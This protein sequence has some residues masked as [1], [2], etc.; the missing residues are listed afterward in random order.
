MK[1]I[2]ILLIIYTFGVIVFFID[3]KVVEIE[4]ETIKQNIVSE[5]QEI[6]E[7]EENNKYLTGVWVSTVFNLDFPKTTNN[8]EQQLKAEIDEIIANSLANDISDIFFQVRPTAD[9]FYYSKIF[10]T[11]VY[12]TGNQ[13]ISAS[14]DVLEYFVTQAHKSNLKLHAWINP[15]RITKNSDDV[16]SDSHIAVTNPELTVT[17]TDGNLYFNPALEEVQELVVDGVLEILQNYDVDGIHLDD[18]FYPSQDFY[19]D[20]Q[21]ELYGDGRSLGDFRRDNVTNLIEKLYKT[22]K[23][24]DENIKF[25]VSPAGIWANQS[26]FYE[27]SATNGTESYFNQYADTKKWVEMGILDY[28]APQIYWQIGFDIADYEILSNWWSQV[29]E[30]TDVLLYIGHANYKETSGI[31]EV[32]EI[33]KQIDMNKQN[34]NING[35]IFF[36]YGDLVA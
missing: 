12:L 22:V 29:V 3:H 8:D 11:S 19:D 14:F 23:T 21:Y 15:Y 24:Y 28:I 36:R 1:K 7:I 32:G 9:A 27:G 34:D 25:G 17:H 4:S 6:I 33:D 13:D 26:S 35:S 20:E 2:L 16:L 5:E 31:F 10:P 30:D 18:Y